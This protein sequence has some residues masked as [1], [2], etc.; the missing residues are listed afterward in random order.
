MMHTAGPFETSSSFVKFR[1][2]AGSTPR[3]GKK[4]AL[5]LSPF[6][7]SGSPFPVNVKL[8]NVVMAI[9]ENDLALEIDSAYRVQD[10][11]G[12][13]P[14]NW[15]FLVTMLTNESGSGMVTGCRMRRS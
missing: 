2:R 3:V 12:T 5:A 9:D 14:V 1:P 4:V 13:S 8:S 11:D 10:T 15:G 7:C 6:S